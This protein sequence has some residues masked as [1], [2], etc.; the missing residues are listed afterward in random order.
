MNIHNGYLTIT[1]VIYNIVVHNNNPIN[2][3]R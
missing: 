1:M 3:Y 2:T